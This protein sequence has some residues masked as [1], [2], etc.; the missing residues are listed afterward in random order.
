MARRTL[1]SIK[2]EQRRYKGLAEGLFKLKGE[3]RMLYMNENLRPMIEELRSRAWLLDSIVEMEEKQTNLEQSDF[4]YESLEKSDNYFANLTRE[5]RDEMIG[6]F[7]AVKQEDMLEDPLWHAAFSAFMST[8]SLGV[9]KEAQVI[10]NQ[11][12]EAKE[13]KE[14]ANNLLKEF[15]TAQQKFQ[16]NILTRMQKN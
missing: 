8:E 1:D 12:K 6:Y 9:D 4:Y 7:N 11:R 5:K 3:A 16:K 15:K 2:R 13:T 10:V 14:N